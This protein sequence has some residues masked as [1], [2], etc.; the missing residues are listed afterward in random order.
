VCYSEDADDEPEDAVQ[1]I[2]G[3]NADINHQF[4]GKY[5]WLVPEYTTDPNAAATAFNVSVQ[6]IADLALDDVAK[7]A[8]GG[9]FRY[10]EPVYDA[11]KSVKIKEMALLRSEGV[12][13]SPP[14]GWAGM[15]KDINEGRG[16]T[17]LYLIWK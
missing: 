15:S 14:A 7:G 17:C 9:K 4:G 11:Q 3:Q 12:V 2:A 5:V 10:V 6:R 13:S 1:E 8:H 16:R